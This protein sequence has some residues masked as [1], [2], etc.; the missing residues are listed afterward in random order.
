M[1]IVKADKGGNTF[2][3]WTITKTVWQHL[4]CS[5]L[6]FNL[7]GN[8]LLLFGCFEQLASWRRCTFRFKCYLSKTT[9]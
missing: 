8:V 5:I 7:S 6:K 2:M 9:H 1:A 3:D 4:Q